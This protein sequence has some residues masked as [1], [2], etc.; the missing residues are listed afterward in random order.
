M[1]LRAAWTATGGGDHGGADWVISS[2]ETIA[3]VH[4]NIGTFSVSS[5]ATGTLASVSSLIITCQTANVLG[6]LSGNSAGYTNATAFGTGVAGQ[7]FNGGGGGGYGGAGGD[8]D[9]DRLGGVAWGDPDISTET[10]EPDELGSAGG[11]ASNAVAPTV[12][13]GGGAI[14]LSQLVEHRIRNDTGWRI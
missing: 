1:A 10:E 6:T 13:I 9:T 8:G 12:G 2:N 3:G 5:G 14:K 11:H 7:A 4:T